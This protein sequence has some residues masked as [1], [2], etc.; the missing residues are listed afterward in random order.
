M[1]PESGADYIRQLKDFIEAEQ[2]GEIA[3]GYGEILRHGP[4]QPLGKGAESLRRLTMGIGEHCIYA[5]EA[6]RDSYK[7]DI[8]DEFVFAAC[9]V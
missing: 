8:T 1:P 4:R 6:V 9:G 2:F 7:Q 3:T 5:E